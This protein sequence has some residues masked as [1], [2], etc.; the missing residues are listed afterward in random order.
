MFT[1]KTCLIYNLFLFVVSRH[2]WGHGSWFTVLIQRHIDHVAAGNVT[3]FSGYHVFSHDLNSN[4]H[5]CPSYIAHFT[6]DRN[7]I[8]NKSGSQKIKSFHPCCD[9]PGALAVLDSDNSS[10]LINHAHNDTPMHI[11]V[12]IRIYQLHEPSGGAPRVGNVSLIP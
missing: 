9:D 2:K 7:N 10:R 5:A 6:V 11:T 1:T 3:Y 4:L 12:C 8:S